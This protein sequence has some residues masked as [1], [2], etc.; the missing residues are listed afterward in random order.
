LA[1]ANV[2]RRSSGAGPDGWGSFLWNDR[3]VARM[4]EAR[5]RERTRPLRIVTLTG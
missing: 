1:Y 2:T 3:R 5:D 4:N